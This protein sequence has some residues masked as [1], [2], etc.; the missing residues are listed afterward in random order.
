[1][2]VEAN[3]LT[4]QVV[5]E[6]AGPAVLLLHGFPDSSALW[7]HQ[8]PALAEAGYRVI[9]PDL[10]GFGESDKPAEVKA[11]GLVTVA[12]DVLGILDRLG[13]ERASVVGHD[14]GAALA[15]LLAMMVPDRVDR[16][17][18]L[19]VGHPAGFFTAGWEQRQRSW[20]MLFFLF[21]G[22]AE[23]GLR[24]DDWRLL[25]EM[26]AGGDVDRY[27]ADLARPGALTA[28][29]NWYRANIRP[30]T[31]A[32]LGGTPTPPVDRP[33]LGVWSS[34]DMFL[35]EEQMTGSAAYVQGSWRYERLDGIGHWIPV[36]APDRLTE[37]LLE[38]LRSDA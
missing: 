34:G 29:L 15:W 21:E 25:R 3:G 10:R 26:A 2:R 36:E 7:R 20:Y 14:W 12:G 4:F 11:Y 32:G 24:Y 33:V 16:L 19:S 18:A 6:G 23:E 37:L 38:F 8:V 17:A 1:M 9:A 28:A 13:V 27:V 31:F 30:E 22:V 5:D 35:T